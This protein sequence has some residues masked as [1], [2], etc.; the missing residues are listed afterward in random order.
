MSLRNILVP[1]DFSDQAQAS[2]DY[3]LFLAKNVGASVHV[4]NS[5]YVPINT[6][7][8]DYVVDQAIWME[9]S[10]QRATE[11]MKLLEE[12]SLKTAGVNYECLVHP[13]PAMNDINDTIKNNGVDLVVMG[14]YKTNELDNFFGNLYTQAIRHAKAPVLLVP[15]LTAPALP[16]S[17][18]FA[19]DLRPLENREPLY[20]LA[21]ILADLGASLK[22]LHVHPPGESISSKKREELAQLQD[23]LSLFRPEVIWLEADD[24]EDGILD[25]SEKQ[26]PDWLMAVSHHYGL[27]EG[28][29]H[30]SH[31][32]K[33]A[34][35]TNV[36]LLV[37]HE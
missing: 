30:S 16:R 14:T 4:L 2:L 29:F 7:E 8:T 27:L 21:A 11:E 17:V 33:L 6:I 25:F 5:Y 37:S 34:R 28:M 18:V 26:K 35:H 22:L 15:E 23:Q 3:A 12:R 31:T 36:P 1:T 32:K 10:R 13:G 19:T 9:Q 24:A 20:R